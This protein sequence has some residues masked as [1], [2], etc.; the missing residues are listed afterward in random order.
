MLRRLFLSTLSVGLV[1]GALYLASID[2]VT[3]GHNCGSAILTR[4]PSVVGVE[5][6]NVADEAFS[7]ESVQS[8]C[9][10]EV[11]GRRFL[12]GLLLAGAVG[13]TVMSSRSRRNRPV[14]FAGDPIV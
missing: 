12:V 1:V 3:H 6:S 9:D 2:I 7:A 10:H 4:D 8:S 11:L 13:A 5:A 14:H